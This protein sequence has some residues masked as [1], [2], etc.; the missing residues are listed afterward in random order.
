MTVDED[1]WPVILDQQG[2]FLNQLE[3]F[4]WELEHA[5]EYG[6]PDEEIEFVEEFVDYYYELLTDENRALADEGIYQLPEIE[7]TVP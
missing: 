1:G 6:L 4:V 5:E 3:A 7:A 2:L